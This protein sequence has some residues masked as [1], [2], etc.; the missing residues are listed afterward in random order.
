M[1]AVDAM[2]SAGHS[3]LVPISFALDF[4]PEFYARDTNR[5]L[6]QPTTPSA[7]AIGSLSVLKRV[8]LDSPRQFFADL[9][10]I[11][12][13]TFPAHFIGSAMHR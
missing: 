9:S 5:R 4:D 10:D 2:L 6:P 3:R 11:H 12:L 8:S 13:E 7:I 1:E